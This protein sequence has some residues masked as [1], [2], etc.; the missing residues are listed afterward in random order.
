MTG[1]DWI[2]TNGTADIVRL[3]IVHRYPPHRRRRGLGQYVSE[4]VSQTQ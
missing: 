4:A 2:E 3:D 1:V